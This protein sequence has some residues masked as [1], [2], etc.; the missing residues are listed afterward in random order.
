MALD[1]RPVPRTSATCSVAALVVASLACAPSEQP[2]APAARGTTWPAPL[3]DIAARARDRFEAPTVSVEEAARIAGDAV[4]VDVR[5]P[6]EIGVSRIRGAVAL[7][8][9]AARRAFLE[10]RRSRGGAA[11][12]GGEPDDRTVLVYCTAGW[13]SAEFAAALA[14]VGVSAWNVEGGLCAWAANGRPI[15]DGDDRPTRRIHAYSDA[16]EGCVPA[17]HE[18]VTA[19]PPGDGR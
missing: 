2:A 16:F 1:S 19:P 15:V 5:T 11:P 7:D 3:T 18:A 9:E 12:G 10:T 6:Q 8:S 17:T 4:L 14:E 13:R